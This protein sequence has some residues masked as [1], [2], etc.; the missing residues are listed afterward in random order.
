MA[1]FYGKNA[2]SYIAPVI[3]DGGN[4]YAVSGSYAFTGS[5]A[6]GDIVALVNLPEGAKV[7]DA[8]LI[9]N[10]GT[11]ASADVSVDG[12]SLGSADVSAETDLK[13]A[14]TGAVVLSKDAALEL[15]LSA[16]GE[17]GK[18]VFAVVSYIYPDIGE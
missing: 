3:S 5:E 4:L 14:V 2:E 9:G 17:A 1:E 18:Q 6:A 7:I 11:S 16:A 8:Y 12:E 15:T 10:A 13:P